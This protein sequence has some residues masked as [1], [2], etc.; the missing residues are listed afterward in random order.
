[1]AVIGGLV[2]LLSEAQGRL[3]ASAWHHLRRL[4]VREQVSSPQFWSA[5]SVQERMSALAD[6]PHGAVTTVAAVQPGQLLFV[7]QRLQELAT[8]PTRKALNLL[9]PHGHVQA[10]ATVLVEPDE[11]TTS[12]DR[13]VAGASRSTGSSARRHVR[14]SATGGFDSLRAVVDSCRPP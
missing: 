9:A 2:D 8:L 11:L 3:P 7:V 4:N 12:R 5:M 1:M 14:L 10:L 13:C 6:D